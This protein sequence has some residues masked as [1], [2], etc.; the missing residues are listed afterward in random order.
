ML[1]FVK[2]VLGKDAKPKKGKGKRRRKI[3]PSDPGE[4]KTSNGQ[5]EDPE[6]LS[7]SEL[8]DLMVEARAEAEDVPL[9]PPPQKSPKKPRKAKSKKSGSKTKAPAVKPAQ[10][11]ARR[12]STPE[13]EALIQQALSVQRKQQKVFANLS[14]EE[15]EKLY[16]MAMKTL[17]DKD[18]GEPK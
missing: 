5:P 2:K 16:V 13:R 17:V 14:R 11:P 6:Y 15:R 4:R 3:E 1:G 8:E 12:P 10:A 9:A 18:F 7:L